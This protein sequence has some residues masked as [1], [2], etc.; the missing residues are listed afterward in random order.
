METVIM[1]LIRKA[2]GAQAKAAEAEVGLAEAEAKV[3]QE[4]AAAIARALHEDEVHRRAD[5]EEVAE[6]EAE[7]VPW[8]RQAAADAGMQAAPDRKEHSSLCPLII[9]ADTGYAGEHPRQPEFAACRARGAHRRVAGQDV[10]CLYSSEAR[11]LATVVLDK[12][13]SK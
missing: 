11:L 9:A 1:G 6:G 5:L 8:S 7:A 12:V 10:G 3:A 13:I 2:A 4:Q